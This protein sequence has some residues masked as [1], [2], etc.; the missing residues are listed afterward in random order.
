MDAALLSVIGFP[1]FAVENPEL[2]KLTR[3]TIE[4]KL[5][6][7]YLL[8]FAVV[9]FLMNSQKKFVLKGMYAPVTYLLLIKIENADY[10]LYSRS[11]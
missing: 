2:I 9:L 6:V 5:R 3:D 7:S 8:I 1:A 10:V 4:E 11:C